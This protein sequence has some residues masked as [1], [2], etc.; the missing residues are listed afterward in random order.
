[1]AEVITSIGTN[2]ATGSATPTGCSGSGVSGGY[3]V[4]F[5]SGAL[6]GVARGDKATMTD[7][8]SYYA[9]FIY[10]VA[11]ISGDTAVLVYVS[12]DMAMGDTSPCDLLDMSWEQAEC[13]FS[14]FYTSIYEWHEELGLTEIYGSGDDAVGECHD[15]SAFNESNTI[16]A[17]GSLNSITLTVHPDSRHSGIAG[18]GARIDLDGSGTT[19]IVI[20]CNE[21]TVE[22]LEINC[23][24][25]T[26]AEAALEIAAAALEGISVRNMILHDVDPDDD[27]DDRYGIKVINSTEDNVTRS[28]LNNF[29]YRILRSDD[30]TGQL[31]HCRGIGERST[32]DDD[33]AGAN[34]YNNTL[35]TVTTT[36]GTAY[37]Y[38]IS[39][40]SILINN[41]ALS[42]GSDCYKIFDDT[43]G[44]DASSHNLSDDL[45][46][47]DVGRQPPYDNYAQ[48]SATG[49][50]AGYTVISS[51]NLHLRWVLNQPIS[52]A[53]DRGKNLA[54]PDGILIDID[55]DARVYGIP[56]EVA[57]GYWDIGADESVYSHPYPA[58]AGAATEYN[59]P[60][61]PSAAVFELAA[62]S[63]SV[64]I[65]SV[66]VS[67][68]AASF[69]LAAVTPSVAT[70]SV[71]VSVAVAA[72]V[73][74]GI[75]PTTL[76]GSISLTPTVAAF[77]LA[78]IAP[79]TLN[80]SISLTPSV[81]AFELAG[82][83]PSVATGSVTAS[84]TAASFELAGV[85]PSIATGSI[86]ASPAVAAF[87]LAGVSPSVSTSYP[88][89]SVTPTA[90][91]FELA[92]ISPTTLNGSITLTPSVAAFE[93]AGVS[94]TVLTGSSTASPAAAAFELAGVSPS[95]SQG[96]ITASPAAATF[97]LAAVSPS[98]IIPVVIT[99]AAASFEL[100][101][102]SPTAVAGSLSV[103]PSV[104][105]VEFAG[106]SP[107]IVM[108][109]ITVAPVASAV[110]FAGITPTTTTA[111]L[112]ITPAV[113]ALE[114]AGISPSVTR[115]S[116]SVTPA[117]AI[118]N[119]HATY[120][121][122]IAGDIFVIPFPTAKFVYTAVDPA[123]G[124]SSQTIAVTASAFELAGVT[125]STINGS[126]TVSPAV[127]V[128][129]FAASVATIHAG[130]EVTPAVAAFEYVVGS[131]TLHVEI[132][133]ASLGYAC[134]GL[135]DY[136]GSIPC[137]YEINGVLDYIGG[138]LPT[139]YQLEKN[140]DY[141][142]DHKS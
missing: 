74:A 134:D 36:N 140:L 6:S 117:A 17:L 9:T 54:S 66:T 64:A 58:A 7:E 11:S 116:I 86:T 108:S 98:V 44:S 78:G 43:Y 120:A 92:G 24:D 136:R 87:E 42:T 55:G 51:T 52:L 13:F 68:V 80:G 105:A 138:V 93:L 141:R 76:N 139:D 123:V 70:G 27:V 131:F 85:S 96:G 126:I 135:V 39:D 57:R 101:G 121:A 103:A 34:Y 37:G 107:S 18:T 90:A 23:T 32:E 1:M 33:D 4:T 115:G 129:E 14:R 112:S 16:S 83:S 5:A 25:A 133:S 31:R 132:A 28:V 35:R 59:A 110:E 60:V 94:P 77:E 125:P 71:A 75:T 122:L 84:P 62:V 124:M 130:I 142:Y 119:Y 20:N 29:I 56:D 73:L 137:D 48:T 15:D 100:A 65:P 12:D 79:T 2:I 53:V 10:R 26:H 72:F 38:H 49:V 63:P 89:T 50:T 104:A 45:T 91:A 106:V 99:P 111:S 21:V 40:E 69:E 30:S 67:P 81:A 88:S 46:A 113:A 109:S 95:V 41:I 127:S 114:L 118:T 22:W 82:V 47:A 19:P 128:V 61:V 3:I 97:E 102:V 8:A